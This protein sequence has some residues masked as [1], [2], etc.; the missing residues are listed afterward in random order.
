MIKLT[1]Q[2]RF[3]SSQNRDQKISSILQEYNEQDSLSVTKFC[4]GHK[5]HKSTFYS[6][7]KRYGNKNIVADK[8]KGFLPV[9]VTNPSYGPLSNTPILFAEVNGI[10]LYHFVSADY[11]KSLV[12]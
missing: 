12:S 5:I 6:W 7:K 4:K 2:R 11:L 3:G 8:R 9:E 1:K 10:R